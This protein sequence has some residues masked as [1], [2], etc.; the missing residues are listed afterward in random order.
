M[1]YFYSTEIS[2]LC[3]KR[4]FNKRNTLYTP[5]K[6]KKIWRPGV[7]L[8]TTFWS[9]L[10]KMTWLPQIW[11]TLNISSLSIHTSSCFILYFHFVKFGL[12][13]TKHSMLEKLFLSSCF[14]P[15]ITC[16]LGNIITHSLPF[17][18]PYA[19]HRLMDLSSLTIR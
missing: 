16:C 9:P 1:S 5:P 13:F 18:W 10:Q 8:K 19:C 6:K 14:F 2:N 3:L 12:Y 15:P 7:T 11:L 17:C 4:T